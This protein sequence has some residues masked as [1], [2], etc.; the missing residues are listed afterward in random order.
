[1]RVADKRGVFKVKKLNRLAIIL[2]VVLFFG[3]SGLGF[4]QEVLKVATDATFPPFE[5]VD[6]DTDECVGFDIDLIKAIGVE[7]GAEVEILNTAWDGILPGLINGNY[8]IVIAA[9][10]IT[11]ERL[12]AVDFSEPYF[13]ASQVLVVRKDDDRIKGLDDLTGMV[14]AVQIGTTGDLEA[15]EIKS[16]KRVARFNYFPEAFMELQNKSADVAIVDLQVALDYMKNNPEG[17]KIV[18]EPFT[19]EQYGIAIRKGRK[20]LLDQVNQ[21]LAAVVEKGI[22]DEIYTKYFGVN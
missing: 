6:P 7:M 4:A 13:N 18:G 10:T 3:A 12:M 9:M 8:D 2:T 16:L 21:A 17:A 11:E 20:E 22:Y 1:M 19:Q 5:S 15:S 14:A